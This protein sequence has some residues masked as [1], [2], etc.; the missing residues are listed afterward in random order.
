[1]AKEIR[2]G[3]R[4]R[5]SVGWLGT[6]RRYFYLPYAVSPLASKAGF[7]LPFARPACRVS[8]ALK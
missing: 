2:G 7:P 8:I 1:M 3:R 5:G 4:L 6:S